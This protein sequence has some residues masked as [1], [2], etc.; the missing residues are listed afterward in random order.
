MA[1]SSG[2]PK[3]IV[4]LLV[5]IVAILFS[6]SIFY[7]IFIRNNIELA[8]VEI[9]DYQG[10]KLSSINDFVENSIK[11][12]QYVNV[13]SY[14]LQITGLVSTPK[15]YTYDEVIGQHQNYKK[16]ITL[17]CV[18][19]WNVKILWEGILV[20]D[21]IGEARPLPNAKVAIFHAY[22]G[23]TTSFPLSY[24]MD[25]NI[26]LANKMNNVTLP[27]ARG[28]PFEL[29]S[30]SK[31]GYK[32]IKWVTQIELS[33]DVNYRGYWEDRGYSNSGNLNESFINIPFSTNA[34]NVQQYG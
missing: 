8:S 23:Y 34:L 6:V 10:E 26:L 2:R 9:R 12:P 13:A 32:W 17:Y 31:W 3:K 20:R 19:G 27:P 4:L 15:N 30:E 24:I 28:F 5:V 18:E 11:G 16:V 25:N 7:V 29:A 21:L 1:E 33:D 14:Q 22:D